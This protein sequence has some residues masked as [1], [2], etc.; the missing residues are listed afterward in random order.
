M[1][2]PLAPPHLREMYPRE[3][4][5]TPSLSTLLC[6]LQ[7]RTTHHGVLAPAIRFISGL[8]LQQ[9]PHGDSITS[10]QLAAEPAIPQKEVEIEAFAVRMCG[11]VVHAAKPYASF[12]RR[13]PVL[14]DQL[15]HADDR[16]D[17]LRP[18]AD[19]SDERP[20]SGHSAPTHRYHGNHLSAQASHQ[21]RNNALPVAVVAAVH[22][23]HV[24]FC[25]HELAVDERVV[26]RRVA[27]LCRAKTCR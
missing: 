25:V 6:S 14:A 7:A 19:T 1:H 9:H 12:I 23:S 8:H 15:G 26:E 22:S 4:E 24:I 13:L 21:K 5:Y 11:G 27:V 18:P 10:I 20:A 2:L 17:V 16:Q 3:A